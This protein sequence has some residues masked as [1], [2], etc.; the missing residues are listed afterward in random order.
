M[1]IDRQIKELEESLKKQTHEIHE[2]VLPFVPKLNSHHDIAKWVCHAFIYL[3]RQDT[4]KLNQ[5]IQGFR[6]AILDTSQDM[7]NQEESTELEPDVPKMTHKV[8]TQM[9]QMM[10]HRVVSYH[11]CI[12]SLVQYIQQVIRRAR[13]FASMIHTQGSNLNNL[14]QKRAQKVK[15]EYSGPEITSIQGPTVTS[16]ISGFDIE[17]TPISTNK[18]TT[19]LKDRAIRIYQ[20]LNELRR[21]RVQAVL[22]HDQPKVVGIDAQIRK[23]NTQV[24]AIIGAR[25]YLASIPDETPM[26]SDHS[27]MEAADRVL[28]H[29]QES[30][31]SAKHHL[32]MDLHKERLNS[33]VEE[34]TLGLEL[35]LKLKTQQEIEKLKNH[36]IQKVCQYTNRIMTQ[37]KTETELL[38]KHL[39]HLHAQLV[40]MEKGAEASR[41]VHLKNIEFRA[42]IAQMYL[43]LLGLFDTS[44]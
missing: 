12:H 34:H 26:V 31:V 37:G 13:G 6:K 18:H 5:Y 28:N 40:L 25:Q 33:M 14:I 23:L 20:Q 41:F 22:E 16:I 7:Y 44:S 2:D 24:K 11:R 32:D 10:K 8:M 15:L 4:P 21:D 35:Y 17:Q 27:T 3:S 9:I 1:E 38:N 30:M 43:E 29:I 36:V 42:Q 39:A 19:M